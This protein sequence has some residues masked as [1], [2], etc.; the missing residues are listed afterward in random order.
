MPFSIRRLSDADAAELWALRL[1]ALERDPT[2][3][4]SSPEEHRRTTPEQLAETLRAIAPD[5]FVVGVSVDGHLRGMA[6]F[7]RETRLKTRHRGVIWGVYLAAELRGQ[8]LGRQMMQRVLDEVR[9]TSGVEWVKL[10]VAARQTAARRLYVSLG[11]QPIGVEHG[12]I[13]V[14]GEDIDEEHFELRTAGTR[15]SG[16]GQSRH[17]P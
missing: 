1:E 2:A 15:D 8:R 9:A 16:G 4:G 13:K 12:A 10:C 6:G 17:G 14:H 11:F 7:S 5:S 3:F